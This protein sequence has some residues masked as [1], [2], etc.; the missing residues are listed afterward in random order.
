[1][2]TREVPPATNPATRPIS[3]ILWRVHQSRLSV[4]GK[5]RC[6]IGRGSRCDYYS[7]CASARWRLPV[8]ATMETQGNQAE[9]RMR[10]P[11][12]ATTCLLCPLPCFCPF[13][14]RRARYEYARQDLDTLGT[15][16]RMCDMHYEPTR[17][18]CKK[19][20]IPSRVR[21][22]LDRQFY[23]IILRPCPILPERPR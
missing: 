8:L 5:Q 16:A 1:L 2:E 21:G 19:K 10:S 23:S 13:V 4:W 22:K 18:R 7:V 15:Y 20:D 17:K 12:D 6:K 3:V 14:P 9:R 11:D